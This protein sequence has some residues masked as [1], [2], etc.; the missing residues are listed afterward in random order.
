MKKRK[1]KYNKNVCVYSTLAVSREFKVRNVYHVGLAF[2]YLWF[3]VKFVKMYMQS[4]SQL[5]S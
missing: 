2:L 1:K 5:E 3:M 4:A